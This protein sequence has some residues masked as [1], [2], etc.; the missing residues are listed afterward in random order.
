MLKNYPRKFVSQ[1]SLYC[2]SALSVKQKWLL[3]L[4]YDESCGTTLKEAHFIIIIIIIIYS[5]KYVT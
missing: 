4:I 5:F 2:I 1:I 3:F